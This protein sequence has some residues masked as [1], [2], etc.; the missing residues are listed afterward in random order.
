MK[1]IF[2][3]IFAV[4]A[5]ALT[6]CAGGAGGVNVLDI[7]LEKCDNEVEKCWK[8]TTSYGGQSADTYTWG[9][10]YVVVYACQQAAKL[11][12]GT[13]VTIA[14]SAAESAEDCVAKL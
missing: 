5:L 6:S 2:Y 12:P 8:Y 11:V 3:S 13:T 14:E 1:K 7:D 9:T 10:E 4:A